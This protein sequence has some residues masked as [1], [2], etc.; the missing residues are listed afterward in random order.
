MYRS[1]L[2]EVKVNNV[3]AAPAFN[4]KDWRILPLVNTGVK[5][6][7][8]M[9][10][11]LLD[12]GVKSIWIKHSGT[13]EIDDKV[14]GDTFFALR[15][16]AADIAHFYYKCRERMTYFKGRSDATRVYLGLDVAARIV[17]PMIDALRSD[18]NRMVA[19]QSLPRL[20]DKKV[21]RMMMRSLMAMCLAI[22]MEGQIFSEKFTKLRKL[23]RNLNSADYQNARDHTGLVFGALVM[24]MFSAVDM[25]EKGW[26]TA[27]KL[28]SVGVYLEAE[29][30]N[31]SDPFVRMILKSRLQNFDGSGE[32]KAERSAVG[33]KGSEVRGLMGM[34]I[35]LLARIT[36]VADIF[37]N[38][39]M[40]DNSYLH[41]LNRMQQESLNRVDPILVETF[42]RMIF[43]F[44]LGAQVVLNSGEVMVVLR[45]NKRNPCRPLLYRLYSD[46]SEDNLLDL[47][48]VPLTTTNI[49]LCLDAPSIQC[50]EHYFSN[51]SVPLY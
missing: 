50:M 28:D 20:L 14:N 11:H 39:L 23:R 25:V 7:S 35:H 10:S 38:Y 37:V 21:D 34:E 2:T 4:P 17:K 19:I 12:L 33:S 31:F 29:L 9:L 6:D 46:E 22:E 49:E 1:V 40:E 45:Q 26:A 42:L 44:P 41:A 32:P 8:S 3:V 13:A 18:P 30:K 43:P 27:Q 47:D 36:R 51:I 24:D 16:Y 5:V 15:Q 48:Q